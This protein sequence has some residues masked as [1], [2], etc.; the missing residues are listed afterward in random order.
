MSFNGEIRIFAQN[1]IT[2]KKKK[3]ILRG[4]NAAPLA[5]FFRVAI[6][7]KRIFILMRILCIIQQHLHTQNSLCL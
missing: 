1:N 6:K 7:C 2:K 3:T 4:E 5:A